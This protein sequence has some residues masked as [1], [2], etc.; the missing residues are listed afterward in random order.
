MTDRRTILMELA[1]GRTR[2]MRMAS[3]L[4]SSA[5]KG[6]DGLLVEEHAPAE[7][8]SRGVCLL[9]SAVFLVLDEPVELRWQGDNRSVAKQVAPGQVSILPADHPY[10]VKLRGAGRSVVVSL[11]RKLLACAAA[12]QG[13]LGKLE[14]IWVHGVDDPLIRELVMALRAEM[15]R[16]DLSQAPYALSL[17][18]ALSAHIVRNYSVDRLRLPEQQG[19]LSTPV[20]RRTLR[21][22]QDNLSEELS[23]HKLASLAALS[24]SHFARAFKLSTGM[25]PHEYLLNCRIARAR[26][27]LL[28]RST[29]LA[30]VAL[31]SGF[32]D[33]AHMTRCFRR[34]LGTTPASL[35]R[36][37]L[38]GADTAAPG[39][40]PGIPAITA[41]MSKQ[42][43]S[44]PRL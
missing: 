35:A 15:R 10:S 11:E 33:Q 44:G 12:E 6:W 20:L 41:G 37:I 9:H 8:E 29:P 18:A 16:S 2:P 7:Y 1:T 14:P 32:C 5:A 28:N 36:S 4:Y 39:A 25:A 42:W 13:A 23:I 22:V 30:E 43:H 17:A 24:A 31:L 27:L 40:V 34:L 3:P 19:G 21:Y 26:Q 38:A